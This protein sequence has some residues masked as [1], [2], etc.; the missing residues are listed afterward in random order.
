MCTPIIVNQG[1]A[2]VCIYPFWQQLLLLDLY[3]SDI[4]HERMSHFVHCSGPKR[5]DV[6]KGRWRYL[7]DG[8]VLHDLLG[9]EFS[10]LLDSVVNLSN[11]TYSHIINDGE[12]WS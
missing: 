8:S 1:L 11:L 2:D 6:I 4:A 5:Y 9:S 12:S 3:G 10:E 7:H